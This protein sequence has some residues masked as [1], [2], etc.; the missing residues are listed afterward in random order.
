MVWRIVG[1]SCT[2]MSGRTG[3]RLRK[4]HHHHAPHKITGMLRKVSLLTAITTTLALNSLR[5]RQS[6]MVRNVTKLA[7]KRIHKKKTKV[8]LLPTQYPPVL[9][10]DHNDQQVEIECLHPGT[11]WVGHH[12]LSEQECQNFVRY[13][14]Q[15]GAYEHKFHKATRF[16]AHR[17]CYEHLHYDEDMA[18]RLYERMRT[19]GLMDVVVAASNKWSPYDYQPIG[20][21]PNVKVYR[22]DTGMWF[23]R[24]VDVS[25]AMSESAQTEITVLVYLSKCKGGATKFYPPGSKEGISFHPEVGSILLHVHGDRCLDHEGEKVLKGIKYVLRTDVVYDYL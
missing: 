18:K 17:D 15:S 14:E 11:I 16:M 10:N 22:Y 24:H 5:S 19:T 13:T 4:H 8:T 2:S 3:V 1:L 12:F 7:S 20:C 23:G 21:N 9:L 6:R 25:D